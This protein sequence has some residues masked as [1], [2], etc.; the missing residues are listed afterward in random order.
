[1]LDTVYITIPQ[2]EA[3]L[4]TYAAD[5]A[6]LFLKTTEMVTDV[7]NNYWFCHDMLYELYVYN[8]E[9]WPSYGTDL[10]LLIAFIQNFLG[11]IPNILTFYEN[12]I[13]AEANGDTATFY[14]E[15]GR[16]VRKITIFDPVESS[17]RR[18]Y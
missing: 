13:E 18:L 15:I 1:M 16:L 3:D 6:N 7:T 10:E 9:K 4:V 17:S 12:L 8:D 5:S 14:Y 11:N 2:Y